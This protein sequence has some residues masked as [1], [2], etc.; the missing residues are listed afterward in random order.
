MHPEWGDRFPW[1]V[2]GVTGA[3]DGV[4]PA[5]FGLSGDLPVGAVLDRWE[6]LRATSVMRTVV[7]SRQVHGV[8][9]CEHEAISTPGLLVARGYDG[10]LTSATS[11]LLTI[12]VADCIPLYVLDSRTR[13]VAML[14]A[15]WRGV[16]GA[17][18]ERAVARMG[19]RW[20][21]RVSDLWV[22][23][24]PA[25]CGR[26][27]EVGPEVHR[28]VHPRVAPPN[29]PTPID[30]RA[31]VAAR[32]VELGVERERITLSAHCTRCGPGAF[33]SHRGGSRGRQMGFLGLR[34]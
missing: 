26:C 33:F 31:A 22:H 34:G 25:I 29:S 18:L 7:H 16:A 32:A 19:E 11:L 24:G 1:A 21:T 4:E 8:E 15:G 12:S 17:I 28:A 23:C 14:H 10:H 30:L 6:R 20:S 13:A 3:G 9:L 27:Y 5:D 2:Q